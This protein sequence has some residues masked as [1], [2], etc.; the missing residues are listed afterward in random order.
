MSLV[1]TTNAKELFVNHPGDFTRDRKL[2]LEKLVGMLI[3]FP[4]RSL[5]VEL[6]SFFEA[7]GN[8]GQCCT[9]SAFSLRRA[10]LD[11]SFFK[12]WNDVLVNSY[13][14]EYGGKAETWEGFRVL[15]VDG[16]NVNMVNKPEVVS[17]FGTADNQYG[18]TAMGRAVQ[19]HDV[20]NGLTVWGGIYPRGE[21]ETAII[22]RQVEHLPEDSLTLFDRGYPSYWLMYLL[23]SQETP[24]KFVMRC[25]TGFNKAV[26][27]FA[28]NAEKDA[29]LTIY[30][31]QESIGKLRGSGYIVDR[32]T[33]L[34]VRAVKVV[35]PEGGIEILLTNLCDSVLH[36]PEKLGWLYGRRWGIETSFGQ[37]KNQMQMEIFSGHRVVCIKQDYFAGLFVSNL[38]AIIAKQ[39]RGPVNRNTA[40]RL[41]RYKVNMN[42]SWA[43]LKNR[44]CFL[45]SGNGDTRGKLTEIEKLLV[46]SIEPVRPGRRSPR[47]K[48]KRKRGK[49]Q[50]FTNYR[51]AV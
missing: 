14:R 18:G 8:P 30:P 43:I 4:K 9:K 13:Y 5:T 25:K 26:E 22:S 48:P 21:S 34:K 19:I 46:K 29:M 50:T 27:A 15:A 39:C 47:G 36:T 33:P 2:P 7:M 16:S 24:R 49:Y 12:V 44:I 51:R 3:N 28:K 38:Q 10:K 23:D 20:L 45:L 42:V 1:T 6:M 17:H 11:P 40:N 31:T 41:H 35:L 32:R 37:Q